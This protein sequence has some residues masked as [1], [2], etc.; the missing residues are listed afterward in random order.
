MRLLVD[1][2]Q[3]RFTVSKPPEEKKDLDGKQRSDRRT[4]ELL[5]TVQ[6]VAFD[7][8]GGEVIT[9][10][11][12]GSPPK[13][14]VGQDV[15]P[16]ELEAIPWVQEKRSA[17]PTAPRTSGRRSRLRRSRNPCGGETSREE[18]AGDRVAGL[19]A[20][21]VCRRVVVDVRGSDGGAH[22]ADREG[23]PELGRV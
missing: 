21:C 15:F 4:G 18:H 20:G 16:V 13:V 7:S 23:G 5:Y 11:V 9:V 3:V 22:R 14:T 12:A 8:T 6:L 19:G 1:T 17:L 10:T 2:L